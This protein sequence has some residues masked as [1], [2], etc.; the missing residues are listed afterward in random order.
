V[1]LVSTGRN[2]WKVPRPARNGF[3]GTFVVRAVVILVTRYRLA[4]FSVGQDL[5][6]RDPDMIRSRRAEKDLLCYF[7]FVDRTMPVS[8]TV[9]DSGRTLA[10]LRANCR[11]ERI[12]C[13]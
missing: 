8:T 4:I 5:S 12:Q 6:S 10:G 3:Q 11:K 1:P 13:R 9:V 2:A 7:A